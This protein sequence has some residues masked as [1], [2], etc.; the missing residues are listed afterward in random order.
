M[1]N[2]EQIES[3][4]LTEAAHDLEMESRG[5]P[6]PIGEMQ[7][8][9]PEEYKVARKLAAGIAYSFAVTVLSTRQAEKISEMIHSEDEGLSAIQDVLNMQPVNALTLAHL[10]RLERTRTAN[11]GADAKHNKPGGS[12]EKKAKIRAIWADGN[13]TSRDRCAEEECANLGMS[14]SAAR[15]ALRNAPKPPSRC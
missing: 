12:R 13:F 5:T 8:R 10:V 9:F 1:S 2:S 6:A 4:L 11:K 7:R 14:F 3:L 15:K